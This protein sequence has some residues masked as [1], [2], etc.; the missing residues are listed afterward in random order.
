MSPKD[1]RLAAA[2]LEGVNR[3]RLLERADVVEYLA[4][5]AAHLAQA[6]TEGAHLPERGRPLI[7]LDLDPP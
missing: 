4:S 7:L 6:I 3:G 2:T 5:I 1:L